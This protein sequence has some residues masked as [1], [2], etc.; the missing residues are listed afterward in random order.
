MLILYF[1]TMKGYPPAGYDGEV[2]AEELSTKYDFSLG[3]VRLAINAE[4]DEDD[5]ITE[6]ERVARIKFLMN[7][8]E[9]LEKD[10]SN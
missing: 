4:T 7:V 10:Q 6:E 2:I 3:I 9:L 1:Q 5:G 8:M